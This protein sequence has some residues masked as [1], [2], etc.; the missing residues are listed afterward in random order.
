MNIPQELN[1]IKQYIQLEY[2]LKP[3]IVGDSVI[4]K[5][6]DIKIEFSINEPDSEC[7]IKDK[8][9]FDVNAERRKDYWGFG[10]LVDY[11]DSKKEIDYTLERMGFKKSLHQMELF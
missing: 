8:Y 11:A 6:K 7:Y 2:D 4:V 3:Y 9:T 10:Y 5:Y 1:S